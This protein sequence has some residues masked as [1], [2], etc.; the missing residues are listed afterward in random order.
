MNKSGSILGGILLVA[1]TS[2]GGGMLALPVLTSLGGFL[3]SLVI[4]FLC[5]LFM[6]CTGLLFLEVSLAMDKES[7]IISMAEKTLGFW[8]KVA[9]WGLY[10]FLFYCLTLAY[11]VGCGEFIAQ[12]F[13]GALPKWFGPILFVLLF[14]PFVYA[15]P[16]VVGP[17]NIVLM[18]GL[19]VFYCIFVALGYQYIDNS[20]F[21]EHNWRLSLMA[22]PICFAAFAYQGIVPTLVHYLNYD[23]KKIRLAII[24]GSFVPL[25]TYIIWEWLILGIIPTHGPGGL[26]EALKAGENAVYPLKKFLH[27][28]WI[29]LIGQ[30]FAFLALVTSFFGVTLGLLDF[31][32]DGLKVKKTHGGKIFLCLIIFVPPLIFATLHPHV[33]LSALDYAGGFGC[34]LLLG[35]LPILMVWS[36]RYRL[37]LQSTYRLP[38]EK[39]LLITLLVFV[40]IELIIE[41]ILAFN[42]V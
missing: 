39:L 17:L 34:A 18:V 15:G 27:N 13:Q 22:L 31:L 4:Y 20:H 3:P 5:W 14:G 12:F 23:V 37:N 29:Y 21:L 19:A 11:I 42:K 10:L 16:K 7:N 36:K 24:V 25:V 32:A 26:E 40:S 30:N 6:T 35:A 41:F 8:G 9:A 28:P 2:I 1:G 33:F 38:G